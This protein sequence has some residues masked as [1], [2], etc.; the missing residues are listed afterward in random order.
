[1]LTIIIHMIQLSTVQQIAVWLL[2]VL[3]AITLHEVAH[4]W[5][6]YRPWRSYR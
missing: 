6:A 2:P 5:A 1:M 4:G 3:F